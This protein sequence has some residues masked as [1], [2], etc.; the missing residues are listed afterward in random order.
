ML[1]SWLLIL[2]TVE[3][4]P[5]GLQRLLGPGL[6]VLLDAAV[7]G[8]GVSPGG[9]HTLLDLYT[10]ELA[11]ALEAA[12][13]EG[14]GYRGCGG[15]VL[16]P[17]GGDH[18]EVRLGLSSD[19]MAVEG[20]AIVTSRVWVVAVMMLKIFSEH[21]TPKHDINPD[22]VTKLTTHSGLIMLS[23]FSN[24]TQNLQSECSPVFRLG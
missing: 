15:R 16:S 13:L 23:S 14:G 8:Q 5:T 6:Q 21:Q 4:E 20:G 10:L 2:E 11:V 19:L 18:A 9:R 12:E 7:Q 24:V 3:L 17:P 1:D 22:I